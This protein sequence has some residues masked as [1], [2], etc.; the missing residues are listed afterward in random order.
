[1]ELEI[2]VD[3]DQSTNSSQLAQ[4]IIS[5]IRTDS[6]LGAASNLTIRTETVEGY[7]VV[8]VDMIVES[9]LSVSDADVSEIVF[10][11]LKDN[12]IEAEIEVEIQIVGNEIEIEN[13]NENE[14]GENK[15][16]GSGKKKS[17]VPTIIFIVA[18]ILISLMALALCIVCY[19]T[20]QKMK[21]GVAHVPSI[22]SDSKISHASPSW[23]EDEQKQGNELTKVQHVGRNVQTNMDEELLHESEGLNTLNSGNVIKSM[24]SVGSDQ[25]VV[26]D[27]EIETAGNVTQ[28]ALSEVRKD[29]G[30]NE[31]DVDDIDA[32]LEG[33]PKETPYM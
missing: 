6:W 13:E 27:D 20:K 18:A 4:S 12:G 23:I 16:K 33:S 25:E 8:F 17:T 9:L 14:E 1:M 31:M 15:E 11:R 29:F 3:V 26:G 10:D 19:R 7:H 30:E 24:S 5:I 2:S 32:R 28:G 22:N 21:L